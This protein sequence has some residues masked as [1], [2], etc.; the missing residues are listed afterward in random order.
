[1]LLH[2]AQLVMTST[3]DTTSH[4]IIEVAEVTVETTVNQNINNTPTTTRIRGTDL[5]IPTDM[6]ITGAIAIKIE[7][8]IRTVT[9]KI[10]KIA[11]I[12]IAIIRAVTTTSITITTE[13]TRTT[14]SNKC[15][16]SNRI[17]TGPRTTNS[18]STLILCQLKK[19]IGKDLIIT[20]IKITKLER[21]METSNRINTVTEMICRSTMNTRATTTTSLKV[22]T[23][24]MEGQTPLINTTI[25]IATEAIHLK[26]IDR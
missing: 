20:K 9:E 15:A 5:M 24:I 3:A 25:T 14:T 2:S 10:L 13:I 22:E 8:I 7:G 16:N 1:M 17:H 19:L 26:I 18:K 21:A 11:I 4:R 6:I 23:K 12:E